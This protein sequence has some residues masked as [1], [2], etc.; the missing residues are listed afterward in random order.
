NMR[1]GV[2]RLLGDMP[3]SLNMV[4]GSLGA[5][6]RLALQATTMMIA[7]AR[8]IDS[9]E[10]QIWCSLESPRS[11]S[12]IARVVRPGGGM[13]RNR[14]DRQLERVFDPYSRIGAI[15]VPPARER[16]ELAAGRRRED[17]LHCLSRSSVTNDSADDNCPSAI[18][19]SAPASAA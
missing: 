10:Q 9:I 3:L 11:V 12:G 2:E 15:R 6:P 5:I 7:S 4:Q 19:R 1:R 17:D 14:G 18:S 16:S 8:L 13:F